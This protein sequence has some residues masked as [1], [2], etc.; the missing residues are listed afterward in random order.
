LVRVP[1]LAFTSGLFSAFEIGS[2]IL[3]LVL[4][5]A[6]VGVSHNITTVPYRVAL[7]VII[8]HFNLVSL[9]AAVTALYA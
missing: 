7:V 4:C 8:I 9:I 3:A 6:L 2:P 5:S 1:V